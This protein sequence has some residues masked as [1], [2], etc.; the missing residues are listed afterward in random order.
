[1]TM[2]KIADSRC[3]AFAIDAAEKWGTP[4]DFHLG[5]MKF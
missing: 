1:M 4:H 2:R 3:A 5:K